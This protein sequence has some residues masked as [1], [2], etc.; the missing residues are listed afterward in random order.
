MA[1]LINNKGTFYLQIEKADHKGLCTVLE[2]L[3]GLYLEVTEQDPITYTFGF[4]CWNYDGMEQMDSESDLRNLLSKI[5]ENPDPD[6]IIPRDPIIPP[7]EYTEE[8]LSKLSWRDLN[9]LKEGILNQ[10]TPFQTAN[11]GVELILNQRKED[12][13]LEK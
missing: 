6:L 10:I 13:K 4:A 11:R 9:E 12:N 1:R 7:R 5:S 8:E 3:D 2:Y